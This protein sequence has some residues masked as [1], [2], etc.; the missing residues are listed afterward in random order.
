MALLGHRWTQFRA[1]QFGY[2]TFCPVR[3]GSGTS[4]EPP[5]GRCTPGRGEPHRPLPQR[6]TRPSG[7]MRC[8]FRRRQRN[9]RPETFAH[10]RLHNGCGRVRQVAGR[11]PHGWRRRPAFSPNAWRWRHEG[12]CEWRSGQDAGMQ[13]RH[14]RMRRP[15]HA[16]R[17]RG[18][19]PW[20]AQE[21]S[22]GQ[23]VCPQYPPRHSGHGRSRGNVSCATESL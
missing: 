8:R 19:E 1:G 16:T 22:C 2:R 6:S 21:P 18:N 3:T 4:F 20:K 9:R 7:A 13:T 5:E 17:M 23:Q 15:V 14:L 12:N 10:P 11:R